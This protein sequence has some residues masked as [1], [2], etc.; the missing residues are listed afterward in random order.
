[1][2][3]TRAQELLAQL[4]ALGIHPN[5][6][7]NDSRTVKPGNLFLAYPG[8]VND[9]RRYMADAVARGAAAVIWEQS[10]FAW[11]ST[12]TAVNL[13]VE[14]LA[15]L[16]GHLAHEVCAHPS[17]KLRLYGVTGTNGKTSVSQWLAAAETQLGRR[18]AIVGTLGNGFP[19]RLIPGPNTT[20]DAVI[21]QRLLNDFL[22]QGADA[23]AM[24]VSSIGLHQGR[25]NGAA[26]SVAGFTNLSRDHLD[27]HGTLEAY[28]ATKALLFEMP[29]LECAVLNLDD[30]FG[31]DMARRLAGSRIRRIG[32]SLSQA[33]EA[34]EIIQASRM[35]TT[36]QG[37]RFTLSLAQQ[38]YVI[39]TPLIGRFNIANL[40]CV[41][42]MLLAAGHELQAIAQVLPHLQAPAGRM[43]RLGGD[44]APLV[45]VDYAH[46]PDALEQVLLSLRPAAEAR[47]GRLTCLFGCGGDRDTGKRPLMGA[48]AA[49]LA[50]RVLL[51]SDNPRSEE[52]AAILRDIQ[53][54]APQATII[55]SRADAIREAILSAASG[56]V[57]LIAG[58]GHEDYQEVAGRRSHFS[59]FEQASL[60]LSAWEGCT[61]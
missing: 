22:A 9:G 2:S 47:H 37:Q 11:D 58:K 6:V 17:E 44:A 16:A 45:L 24:E 34:M 26:I 39:E 4:T 8:E 57:V 10:G 28:A 18:C 55:P 53:A 51:T 61:P 32:Y 27:Y 38:A 30:A 59:D 5:G 60:A 43:Q 19:G 50:D 1:M 25:V 46:T 41:A 35:E 36:A 33:D 49:R 13:P 29:S 42:G 48:V 31:R 23:T 15:E 52:P 54:G 14:R 40:L 21:L 20:P 3:A 56:D 12:L 7:C